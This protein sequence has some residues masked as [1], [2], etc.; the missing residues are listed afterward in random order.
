MTPLAATYLATVVLGLPVAGMSDALEGGFVG[1]GDSRASLYVNVA[2]VLTNVALDPVF[3]FGVGPVPGMG[4]RGAALATVAGYVAGFCLAVWLSVGRGR[5]SLLP[6][7]PSLSAAELRELLAVGLPV[8]GRQVVRQTVRVLVVGVVAV[9]GGAAGLTAYTVGSRVAS[10]AVLPSVGLQQATQSVVGQ[11]LGAGNRS[12]AGHATRVGVALAV[13]A[14]A[15]LGV[16]QWAVP[17]T[18]A[19]LFVPGLSGTGRALTVAYLTILAYGYPAI[20]AADLLVAGFDG[21]RRTRTSF[22]VDLLK[23]WGV[24]LPAA[25]L[26]LPTAFSVSL[27]G[28]TLSPGLGFGMAAIF[29]AVTGSNVL[30]AVGLGVYY[31]YAVR[32]GLFSQSA[33]VP[34]D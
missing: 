29:W 26:S 11:N 12:R 18:L 27:L 14:L 32:A 8:T 20:G 3:I 23:Y 2:T 34:G 33:A 24:R 16:V 15:L 21:A 7:S 30:A 13:G 10:V 1:W 4:V 6:S 22:V 5:P 17:E 19:H 28:V 31:R 9:T 25:A